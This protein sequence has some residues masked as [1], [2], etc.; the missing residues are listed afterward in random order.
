MA[1]FWQTCEVAK[2]NKLVPV[3][4]KHIFSTFRKTNRGS[5]KSM[6]ICLKNVIS[7]GASTDETASS[8]SGSQRSL[9]E[10]TQEQLLRETATIMRA[11]I[12]PSDFTKPDDGDCGTY[13][14]SQ[15]DNEKGDLAAAGASI[16]AVVV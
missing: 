7:T 9:E 8:G 3:P 1:A 13:L 14:D 10:G 11:T 4:R 16:F 5:N 6:E 12:I 15:Q 2:P